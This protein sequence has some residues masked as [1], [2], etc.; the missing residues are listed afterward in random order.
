MPI[1]MFRKVLLLLLL[2]S[3]HRILK[4]TTTTGT[5][6]IQRINAKTVAARTKCVPQVLMPAVRFCAYIHSVRKRVLF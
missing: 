4:I 3:F 2:C 5:A 1:K 6:L